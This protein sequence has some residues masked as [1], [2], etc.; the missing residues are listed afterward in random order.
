M[1]LRIL[2]TAKKYQMPKLVL[3]L[4]KDVLSKEFNRFCHRLCNEELKALGYLIKPTNHKKTYRLM[5]EHG[6]LLDKADISG[7]KR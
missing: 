1:S 6:L 3:V 4:I 5:K 2:K 7:F